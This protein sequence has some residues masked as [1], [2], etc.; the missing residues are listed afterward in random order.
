MQSQPLLVLGMQSVGP[1]TFT[2]VLVFSISLPTT[3]HAHTEIMRCSLS[4]PR[5]HYSLKT[6]GVVLH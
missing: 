1:E 6:F 2:S 4:C 5:R 3:P